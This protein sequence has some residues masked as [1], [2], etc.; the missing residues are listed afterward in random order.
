MKNNLTTAMATL[1]LL[2]TMQTVTAQQ[3]WKMGGNTPGTD[4]TLGTKNSK[5]LI[6]ISNNLERLRI[7]K[8]GKIG[9]GTSN[10]NTIFH[11][12]GTQTMGGDLTF[13]KGTQSIQFANPGNNPHPMIYMF[14]SGTVNP[15]RMVISLSPTY[16]DWG[17]QF[18]DN[19]NQFNFLGGGSSN[20]LAINLSNGYIGINNPSP[21]YK[22]D[23]VGD[24]MINGTLR[25]KDSSDGI[26]FANPSTTSNPMITMFASG[27]VNKDRM[28]IAHS[29][30]YPTWGLQ[31]HDSNDAF[32]FISGGNSRLYINLSSGNVGIGT[33]NPYYRLEVCGTI[34]AKEVRVETGWCDYVFEKD[35]KLRS[36]DELEKFINENKHLPGIAPAKEVEKDGLKL[37]E[38]NKA[39]MEKIEELTLY[40]LQLNKDNQKLQKEIDELKKK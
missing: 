12:A 7:T 19:L 34:R 2:C 16:P 30:G 29:P 21:S 38:M 4:T 23:I 25:F 18:A 27:T 8:D 9:I 40:V 3:Y 28:V 1:L 22:L 6:L 13:L 5:D 11:V 36:F 32:D 33:N 39:M 20:R 24:E 31:Y 37:A 17:L 26:Q 35:Y 10:P 15:D 14:K